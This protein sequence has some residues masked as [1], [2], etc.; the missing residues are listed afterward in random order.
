MSNLIQTP[1][2]AYGSLMHALLTCLMLFLFSPDKSTCFG[3]TLKE[4]QGRIAFHVLAIWYILAST[5]KEMFYGTGNKVTS[6]SMGTKVL[7]KGQKSKLQAKAPV[8]PPAN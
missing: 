3:L 1:E 5:I 2:N 8:L 7:G 6:V 4:T